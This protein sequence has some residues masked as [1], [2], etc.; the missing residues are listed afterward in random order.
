M[1]DT[2]YSCHKTQE[3]FSVS[4]W[5]KLR[6]R[7]CAMNIVSLTQFLANHS[8]DQPYFQPHH[9]SLNKTLDI[10]MPSNTTHTTLQK[11]NGNP[12]Q[13]D[14]RDLRSSSQRNNKKVQLLRRKTAHIGRDSNDPSRHGVPNIRI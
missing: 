14:T 6:H 2:S 7:D 12:F 11:E 4:C 10:I 5:A 9:L 1:Y 13:V 3:A 8:A